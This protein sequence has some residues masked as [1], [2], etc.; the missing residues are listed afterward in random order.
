MGRKHELRLL[1]AGDPDVLRVLR[2]R[3]TDRA[4]CVRAALTTQRVISFVA[5]FKGAS[6]FVGAGRFPCKKLSIL[7]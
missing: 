7:G 4:G 6:K 3:G 2:A 5:G 1:P